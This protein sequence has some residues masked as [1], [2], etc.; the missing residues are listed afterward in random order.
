[1]QKWLG[2]HQPLRT[3][4]LE[5]MF[6]EI[7]DMAGAKAHRPSIQPHQN[8]PIFLSQAA[9]RVSIRSDLRLIGK[10]QLQLRRRLADYALQ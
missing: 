10:I 9:E 3:N 8:R 4:P 6:G 1:M 7:F 2:R 5:E